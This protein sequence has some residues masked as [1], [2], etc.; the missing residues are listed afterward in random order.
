MN[1]F[2]SCIE[3]QKSIDSIVN[4]IGNESITKKNLLVKDKIMNPAHY[5]VMMGETSSGKSALINSL[6]D[7]KILIESVKPTTGVVT[8]VII[9]NENEEELTAINKDATIETLDKDSF[10]NLS[11]NPNKTLHRL[12]YKGVC[13]NI[14]YKGMRI[15]DTP[16]YG[17]LIEYHEEVL[18]EFIPE[19]DFIVYVVSYRVGLGDDDAQFL[20]YIGEIIGNDVEVV[21]AINM[22]PKDLKDDNKRILEI[23]ENVNKCIHKNVKTFFIESS[24][25]KKP[26]TAKLWDYIYKKINDEEKQNR[27]LESLENYQDYILDECNI[28]INSK[29]ANIESQKEEIEEKLNIVGELLDKKFE[30]LGTI[31]RG[32]TK[33]KVNS[34]KTIDKSAITIKEKITSYIHDESKWSKKEETFALMQDYYVPN[35][36]NEETDNLVNYIEDDII[37]LDKT[38]DRLL[39]ESISVLQEKVKVNT[40]SY[41]EVMDGVLKQHIGD[42]IKQATGEMFRKANKEGEY[43]IGT[44]NSEEL[45]SLV[46]IKSY[47]H[48]QYNIKYFLKAIKASS[49]KAITRYL[50]VFTESIFY[51]YDSLT[52]QKKIKEISLNAID[53]WANDVEISIKKYLEMLRDTNKEEIMALFN[54]LS[55]EFK[56]D[57]KLLVNIELEELVKLKKQI[58]FLLHKCLYM[59]MKK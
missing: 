43:S 36:T 49:L 56:E 45:N 17:S 5:V 32:F 31:D 21:L 24:S 30:I 38:I 11:V 55:E 41:T 18:K 14:K 2:K 27:L 47:K 37:L 10:D 46:D 3:R 9:S 12:R 20:K 7:N 19:S 22:C 25:E 34:I 35:L 40:P 57:E 28:K 26:D 51:L 8:E 53:N 1:V 54:Q 44:S 50:S 13:K 29:I 23:K 39:K 4:A 16:G 33:I 42:E 48:I 58:E 6:F 59:S 15:F 52:W